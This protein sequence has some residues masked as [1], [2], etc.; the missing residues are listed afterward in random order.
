MFEHLVWFLTAPGRLQ[1]LV[2]RRRALESFSVTA[3]TIIRVGCTGLTG[4][5]FGTEFHRFLIRR[6]RDHEFEPPS[7]QRAPG[8]D[9]LGLYRLP[10]H[11]MPTR[12]DLS[13]EPDLKT[14]AL[15]C[16]VTVTA[17]VQKPTTQSDLN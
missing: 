15:S 7:S 17:P 14:F 10:R 3:W 13:L 5:I 8:G 1:A 11:V 4:D 12:Y 2:T 6:P 9:K 16:D